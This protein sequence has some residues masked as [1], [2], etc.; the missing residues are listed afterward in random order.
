M[1]P[2]SKAGYNHKQKR[3][4]GPI[5]QSHRERGV[6]GEETERLAWATVNKQDGG[7]RKS[8]F[9][10]SGLAAGAGRASGGRSKRQRPAP[11]H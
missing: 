1:P 2:A 6:S 5:E 9:E 4:R 7:G 11:N 10:Q 8:G 3:K